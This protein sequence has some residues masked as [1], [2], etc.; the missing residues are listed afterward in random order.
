MNVGHTLYIMFQSAD[1][2]LKMSVHDEKIMVL[3][4]LG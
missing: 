4:S 3:A 2:Y 1:G